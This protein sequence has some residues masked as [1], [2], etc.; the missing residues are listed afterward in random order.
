[1]KNI[2][3]IP[4]RGGSGRIPKKNIIDFHGKPLIAYTIEAALQSKLFGEHVYVSSDSEEILAVAKQYGAKCMLRP[5][6]I[7]QDDSPMEK[8]IFHTLDEVKEDF[9]YVC[10]LFP[11]FPLRTEDE[12]ISSFDEL[13]K[14]NANA[15]MTVTDFQWLTPFWAMH[16]GKNGLDF[17]FGRKYLIDSKKLPKVY[18]LAD[19]VRWLSVPYFKKVKKF[20]GKGVIKFEIPFERSIEIDD[21]KNL[22]LAKKL[23][24]IAGI[25]K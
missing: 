3:I 2:C 22:E 18:A 21:Y 1:M 15:L 20:Y 9:D 23:Y 10:M 17:F 14:Q 25:K 5:Q 12:I 6:K 4:A 11:N 8:T 13:R 16:E 7:A 19:A 24:H